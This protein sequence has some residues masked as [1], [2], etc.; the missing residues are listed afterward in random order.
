MK[1][2]LG[3]G[4]AAPDFDLEGTGG[5]RYRLSAYRG[6]PVVL[7]FYPADNTPVC[8]AQLTSYSGDL[9]RFQEVG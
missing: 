4:D 1:E 8:T 7:V 9:S 5:Q 6:A 2:R 3:A